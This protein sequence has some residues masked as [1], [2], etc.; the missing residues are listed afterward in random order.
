MFVLGKMIYFIYFLI[1]KLPPY[2][3]AGFDLTTHNSAGGDGAPR[4]CLQ[5]FILYLNQSKIRQQRD[6]N[7]S[8]YWGDLETNFC[9][10][11]K[12]QNFAPNPVTLP[13]SWKWFWQ[14]GVPCLR[15]K[16]SRFPAH[17]FLWEPNVAPALRYTATK[18]PTNLIASR[19][20]VFVK[21]KF[22]CC[23]FGHL[24]IFIFKI[25][26]ILSQHFIDRFYSDFTIICDTTDMF[27]LNW[28]A[29]K[30][31]KNFSSP[32]V[33]QIGGHLLFGSP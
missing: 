26:F 7:L 28:T 32:F 1:K 16:F 20:I 27:K 21:N 11:P 33:T 5:G 14:L 17:T 15:F 9:Q 3:P 13:E 6:Q 8:L 24:F 23:F 31:I 18:R 25:L 4:P 10:M 2:T 22:F 19:H 29:I 12:R 30:F